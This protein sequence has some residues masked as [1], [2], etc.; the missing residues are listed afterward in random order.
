MQNPF[1]RTHIDVSTLR[2]DAAA[3][4]RRLQS[5]KE[6]SCPNPGFWYPYGTLNNF[7]MFDEL[8]HG[9]NR[10]LL[11]L[12]QGK[13]IADIGAADGDLAFFLEQQYRMSTH[14]IDHAPTNFNSLRGARRMKEA[15][16]SKVEIHDINLDE[17]EDLPE[18][19]Y[20]LIF[21]LGILYHLKNP[22]HT[23]EALAH[24]SRH[25]LLS[26]RVAK[27]SPDRRVEFSGLPIAYLL[28]A[29][30]SNNDSTNYWIFTTAGLKRIIDRTGWEILD[31][32]KFGDLKQSDPAS[33]EHD[34]RAF[35]LLRSRHMLSS[36]HPTRHP[37]ASESKQS[38]HPETDRTIE[39]GTVQF[40]IKGTKGWLDR[41]ELLEQYWAAHPRFR[42]FKNTP[43]HCKLIDV[44]AGS[45]GLVHWK[46]WVSP[47]RHD[48]EMY[49]VDREMGEFFNQYAG[50]QICDLENEEVLFPPGSFDALMLSHILEYLENPVQLMGKL[51][52]LLKKNGT[53]YIE[54]CTPDS[55]TLPQRE[56]FNAEGLQVSAI[57]ASD[58]GGRRHSLPLRELCAMVNAAGLIVAENGIIEHKDIEDDLLS[59]GTRHQDMELTTYAVW[60][61]LGIAQYVIAQ[62]P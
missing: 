22:F 16:A 40:T 28:D 32:R 12:A 42:F 36:T 53:L 60:S 6:V 30:E 24:R 27:Y 11:D 3:F 19:S 13:P 9:E 49:A 62:H 26:T 55:L 51:A 57:S 34:E 61:K 29:T 4:E 45:G 39:V 7:I 10:Y 50:Y 17:Y 21:F 2:T 31:L 33:Q 54:T 58:V 20:G 37:R 5:I 25:C 56:A 23:L 47:Q 48:I 43:F 52:A 35:C 38:P 15:L 14:I 8:L 41:E 59:Y 18:T 44:G 46:T 1:I